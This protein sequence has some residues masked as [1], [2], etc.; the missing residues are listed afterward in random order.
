MFNEYFEEKNRKLS[1]ENIY[2]VQELAETILRGDVLCGKRKFPC[3]EQ[4]DLQ[5]KVENH[6]NR[7]NLDESP[8]SVIEQITTNDL[9]ASLFAKSPTQQ[10]S[11]ELLQTEY[12]LS[13][14]FVLRK[15]PAGGENARR[16]YDGNFIYG[17]DCG[18][19]ASKSIDFECDGTFICAKVTNGVGGG[20][21][22][23]KREI[24]DFLKQA[25]L[26]NDRH[27]KSVN[28]TV[29]ADGNYYTER[30][31]DEFKPFL[32]DSIRVLSSDEF[33]I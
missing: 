29:L 32:T 25:N 31:L 16:L 10:N 12:A 13:R 9:I 20:Q 5:K 30:V 1:R 4:R 21:D 19:K 6:I 8:L 27:L 3:K 23:V 24:L 17:D 33:K 18:G 15:L 26:Y 14:G 7:Y 2:I 11:S 28:F 22:G